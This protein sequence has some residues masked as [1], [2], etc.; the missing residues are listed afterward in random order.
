MNQSLTNAWGD[1]P[2]HVRRPSAVQLGGVRHQGYVDVH[3]GRAAARYTSTPAGGR[4]PSVEPIYDEVREEPVYANTMREEPV[5]ANTNGLVSGSPLVVEEKTLVA[6]KTA[7]P[8][9]LENESF[10]SQYSSASNLAGNCI[11]FEVSGIIYF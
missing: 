5:Y 3:P 8:L 9:G 1:R 2:S 7:E 11:K 10:R 4:V 6:D